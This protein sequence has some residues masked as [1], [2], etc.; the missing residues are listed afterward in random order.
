METTHLIRG[1]EDV[2]IVLHEP[3]HPGQPAQSSTSLVPVQNTELGHPQ[4]Q[5]FVTPLPRVKDQ[6]VSGAVHGLDGELFLVDREAEHVFGVILPVTRGLPEFR[7]VN[8]GRTDLDVA[9]FVVFA[10]PS[11]VGESNSKHNNDDRFPVE[12]GTH[13]DKLHQRVVNPHPHGQKERAPRAQFVEHEQL[14]LFPDLPVIPLFGLFHKL[15]VLGHQFR[16]GET[17][18]VDTLQRV[19]LRVGQ[20][21]RRR[22]FGDR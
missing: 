10:L 3:S 12:V 5:L 8:V 20:E 15:L 17:D 13:S 16:I 6:T 21:V 18:P 1:T 4:R 9:T 11:R 22:V 2:C 14:L 19:I 7:V